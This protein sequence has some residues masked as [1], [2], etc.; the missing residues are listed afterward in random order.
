MTSATPGERDPSGA[1]RLPRVLPAGP[2]V[3]PS[4][5]SRWACGAPRGCARCARRWSPPPSSAPRTGPSTTTAYVRWVYR[6]T[7]G[8]HGRQSS[9]VTNWA[10]QLTARRTPAAACSRHFLMEP[11]SVA[12]YLR[13]R[14]PL[15]YLYV[16]LLAARPRRA[17]PGRRG[18]GSSAAARRSRTL[19]AEFFGSARVR[20][21]VRLNGAVSVLSTIAGPPSRRAR[22]PR[23]ERRPQLLDAAVGRDPAMGPGVTMEQLAKAGGVTKPI[24]YRHFGDRDGLIQAD[25]RAVLHRPAHVG[26][27]ARWPPT[28]TPASCCAP[29]STP[30]SRSS[31]ATRTSTASWSSSRPSAPRARTR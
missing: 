10:G 1:P 20:R 19:V 9:R 14:C 17:P 23:A 15:A 8:T 3:R 7:F 2:D 12:K 18:S 25:R 26:H 11:T 6:Y 5:A 13:T 16:G 24:L 31:S 21:A 27:H 22:P 28:P 30:T 4:S 29:P